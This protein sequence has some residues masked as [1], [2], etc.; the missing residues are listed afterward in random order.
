MNFSIGGIGT[1]YLGS[2]EDKVPNGCVIIA[3]YSLICLSGVVKVVG[4]I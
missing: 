2:I 3:K 1:S 4:V